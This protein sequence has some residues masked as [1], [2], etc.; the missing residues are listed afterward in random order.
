LEYRK[1]DI[2]KKQSNNLCFD[3]KPWWCGYAV[4][5]GLFFAF[6]FEMT[7]IFLVLSI[8]AGGGLG[9]FINMK[10]RM[11]KA[12]CRA[13]LVS[14]EECK[15]VLGLDDREDGFTE[16][17][18]MTAS[19]A[20]EAYCMREF[21]YT[22]RVEF[23]DGSLP[24]GEELR[25]Y[26]VRKVCGVKEKIGAEWRVLDFMLEPRTK[27]VLDRPYFLHVHKARG[28][29]EKD[30]QV[31]VEYMSG[32]KPDEMPLQVQQACVEL[33]AWNYARHKERK[34]G[35]KGSEKRGGEHYE[36]AMPENVKGLLE[37]W[38]RKTI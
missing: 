11:N 27:A 22:K 30:R 36:S 26:P 2:L 28:A 13:G 35:V 25:E 7:Q 1:S 18:V 34:I 6:F 24:G 9:Y 32:Y 5:P 17:L 10:R 3:I 21:G 29:S 37:R 4:L 20:I 23:L 8:W 19:A 15:R 38:R 12:P 31:V 14:V 33:V 16:W